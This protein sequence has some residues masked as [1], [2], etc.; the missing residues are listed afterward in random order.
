MDRDQ[1][2]AAMLRIVDTCGLRVGSDEYAEENAS[3]GLST[4]TKKHVRV[5]G[6]SVLFDFPAKS[7]K[8]AQVT[9][10]DRAVARIVTRLLDQRGRRL[11][12]VD[13]APITA[14]ELNERLGQ[15]AGARVT[16][17]DFRTWQGTRVAFASLRGHLPPPADMSTREQRVLNAVD[18]ASEFLN[19]TRTV[20]RAHYVH[21]HVV[22]AYLDGNFAELLAARR[23]PRSPGL[24]SD[25]RA[26]VGFLGTLLANHLHAL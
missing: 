17:K 13:G 9:L 12:T 24:D 14:D 1:V 25:E 23:P 26:L 11:F 5:V 19:N 21:P 3:Y 4:L 10:H 15:L 2:L 6:G 18:A 16:A 8:Q 7:G 20:A 22:Q